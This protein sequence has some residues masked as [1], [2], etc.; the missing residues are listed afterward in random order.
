M[1]QH[2]DTYRVGFWVE[3]GLSGSPRLRNEGDESRKQTERARKETR[4]QIGRRLGYHRTVRDAPRIPE[5][6]GTSGISYARSGRISIRDERDV[7]IERRRRRGLTRS[8]ERVAAVAETRL[9]RRAEGVFRSHS[10]S[11]RVRSHTLSRRSWKPSSP[12]NSCTA[13]RI[14]IESGRASRLI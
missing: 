9:S 5:P 12:T 3:K 8:R 14:N 4:K 11:R 6:H 1:V 13:R 2:F 7:A 10:R